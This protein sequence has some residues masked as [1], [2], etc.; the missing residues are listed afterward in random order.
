[1][2]ECICSPLPVGFVE[3]LAELA[4]PGGDDP[5]PHVVP[6]LRREATAKM[7]AILTR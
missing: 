5:T 2:N 3:G 4:A 6:A 1:M 7:D